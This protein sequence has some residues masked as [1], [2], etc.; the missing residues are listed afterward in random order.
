MQV[1]DTLKGFRVVR[2]RE[3]P[4]IGV[5][6]EMEHEK[7]GARLAWVENGN[8]NKLF[9][10]AFKTLPWDDTGVFHILEHSVLAGSESYPVKEP[11]L[12]LLK[13]SMNTFLNAMTFPDKT[14][15]PVSSRNDKDYMNLTRV[16]LDAVFRPAI[17]T[18]PNIF[19]Q[20]GWHYEIREKTDEPLF[21][22]VVFNEMKGAFASVSELL[23]VGLRRLIFPDSVYGFVSG[24]DP[25]AIPDLT[26]E[27]FLEAHREFY[28]PSNALFY[29]DGAVPLEQVLG[30]IDEYLS[31]YEKDVRPHDIRLQGLTP[32]SYA[33]ESYPIGADEDEKNKCQIIF[34]RTFGDWSERKKLMAFGLVATYLTDSNDSPLTRA[35]LE[36][37]LAQNV[38]LYA[39][40][41]VAEPYIN[42][43]VRDT[44][45]EK[46]P[47]IRATVREALETV[48]RE[49]IPEEE[50]E[51]LLSLE[52]YSIRDM[53]EPA[54]LIRNINGLSSWLYGGDVMQYLTHG[55][56]VEAVRK[57]VG[58]SY[59]TDLIRETLLDEAHLSVFVLTPSKTK[60]AETEA[61]EAERLKKAKESWTA[62]ETENYI[63][64]NLRLDEWQESEDSEEAKATL[65]TLD[66]SDVDPAPFYT[67]T[68]EKTENGVTVLYHPVASNGIS[69]VRAYYGCGDFSPD[70]LPALR[71]LCDVLG[72]LPT[73]SHTVS[74]LSLLRRK[75]VGNLSFGISVYGD[76]NDDAR[77][78]IF[79]NAVVDALDEKLG[80]AAALTNEILT[81]TLF[82]D[83]NKIRELLLQ[84]KNSVNR[85][86]LGRGNVFAMRRAGAGMQA[87]CAVN[88]RTSG[89]TDYLWLRDFAN[90]FDEKID[91]FVAFAEK[92]LKTLVAS[93]RLTLSLTSDA[94]RGEVAAF[95]PEN[96]GDAG[97]DTLEILPDRAKKKEA[98]LIPSGVSY[99]S[100]VW[101]IEDNATYS[102]TLQVLSTILS[103]GYLW[104]EIRVKGGAYGCGFRAANR[105]PLA[106]YSYRD[107]S[108]AQSEGVFDATPDFL[109]DLLASGEDVVK[110]VISTVAATEP[111]T[112]PAQDGAEA[113]ARW[114]TGRAYE[115]VA[116]AKREILET[117]GEAIARYIPVFREIAEKG[118]ECIVGSEKELS[119]LPDEWK[120]LTV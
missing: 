52:E 23:D 51:A 80:N 64:K 84:A 86:L 31:G 96:A 8:P 22:G 62:A 53:E 37:G 46:L 1:N 87:A 72:E 101:K 99:A 119:A 66:I 103:F 92:T 97:T 115:D 111:L 55:E 93:R 68:E 32:A 43:V 50:L 75:Y 6:W 63:E 13:S 106:F 120:K 65:P 88:E 48:V 78:R 3:H 116:K 100:K 110:Y 26:Y 49:G 44:E 60:Q 40:T 17:F 15:Y 82:T 61:A 83:K 85:S 47:E 56:T 89:F 19:Y 30:L 79:F 58:A 34:G 67:E 57:E 102:G 77:C 18:N 41:G 105:G 36:K 108:P 69:H 35:L 28:H 71:F 91:G 59:F 113:D 20:E 76:R 117:N 54:G 25:K 14:M 10:V 5:L 45:K 70:D 38:S 118:S 94:Y 24:G 74:G 2:R 39:E 109:S 9:S 107:P 4:E 7:S 90:A 42:L 98:I 33:E 12:D 21:K 11:F 73:A 95:I 27:R 29:L 104:G 112:E 114:F 16:Y 81:Q